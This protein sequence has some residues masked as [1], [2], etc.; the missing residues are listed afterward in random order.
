MNSGFLTERD[1]IAAIATPIG[2]N[3]IGIVRIS[4]DKAGHIAKQVLR[5][6]LKEENDFDGIDIDKIPSHY[7]KHGYIF[8]K[9]KGVVIDEVLF[10]FM[11][12]PHSYT[13][14]DVIEIHSH[15]GPV[16]LNKLI[17]LILDQG[18]RLA[19]PGEFTKRAFLNGRIDLSQAEAVEEM[20]KAGSEDALKIAASNLSGQFKDAI[21]EIRSQIL[22]LMTEI[23]GSL[24]FSE[25]VDG[26][27]EA[28]RISTI[29][30]SSVIEPAKT[31]V[32]NFREGHLLRDGIR[33]DI[34]GRPNVGKSSLLN[35][36]INKERAI[37]TEIP[38]TTRDLI[39][40]SFCIDGINL[41]LT[42]T[43][44]IH[45][46][47]DPVELLGMEKARESLGR[48]DIVLFVV[49]GYQGISDE[50]IK[51]FRQIRDKNLIL[52]VNKLDKCQN[53]AAIAVPDSFKGT[54]GICIS[55]RYGYG[56]CELKRLI[57]DK[58]IGDINLEPGKSIIPNIRQK[59]V[60]EAVLEKAF[61]LKARIDED[62][63]QEIMMSDLKF[64]LNDL[65]EILGLN[66]NH[67][68]L[69]EIF[70]R[71]CIGK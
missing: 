60:L 6:K 2:S 58:S 41:V 29:L 8:E 52:V 25:E 63:G 19:F 36:L 54:P 30:E 66:V 9:K 55:A 33:V 48:A 20:I 71:F 22:F 57:K 7:L 17:N 59:R 45:D 35:Y 11:R 56:I 68:I 44:G 27:L 39:E 34:I 46:S 16:I 13:R 31:L 18:A 28:D 40:E 1:T 47:H 64:I 26:S 69:D 10:V 32:S 14:E 61:D 38:G 49:D 51:V 37:V 21:T 65:D 24:E 43:A 4:G 53:S 67:D 3:G 15:S 23:E 42:D 12:S 70:N 62:M 50:D 5:L